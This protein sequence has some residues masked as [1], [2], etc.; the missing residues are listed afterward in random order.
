MDA[1]TAPAGGSARL[2]GLAGVGRVTAMVLGLLALLAAASGGLV[3][4]V[5]AAGLGAGASADAFFLL[6]VSLVC[7]ALAA[8]ARGLAR[9]AA[10]IGRGDGASDAILVT[11]HGRQGETLAVEHA[12]GAFA[13]EANYLL[14]ADLFERILVADRPAFLSALASATRGLPAACDLRVRASADGLPAYAPLEMQ[15]M[16]AGEGAARALWRAASAHKMRAEEEARAREEAEAANAA[17]SR[18]LAA[19]SHELRT[20][21]NAIIGFSELLATEAGAPLDAERKADYARIIHESGQHL[22]SVVNDILD[23]SRVEAGAYSLDLATLDAG[24]LVEG[25]VEMMALDAARAGVTLRASVSG[26]LPALEADERALR[27]IVINLMANAVKFTPEG[28][29]VQ[30]LVRA[31]AGRMTIRVRDTGPGMTAE[32]VSRVGE[33]FFQAG[34]AAQKAQGSGLG[35]AVVKGLVRLHGGTFEVESAPGRGTS[36]SVCL[37]LVAPRQAL[38][39]VEG[40]D[41]VAAFPTRLATEEPVRRTA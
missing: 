27:Q 35:L 20:P 3:L 2:A 22:L 1:G 26:R 5:Q 36:V 39:P 40:A 4:L 15:C 21:L 11:R 14:G 16:P 13:D 37:P 38:P 10:Q 28:G 23:L 34:D 19:M 33:P 25:C 29:K 8:V 12:G 24:A 30:V 31:R 6:G 32:A 7:A 41:V 18:F 17:K 9:A